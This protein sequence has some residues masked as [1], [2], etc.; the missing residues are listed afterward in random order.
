MNRVDPELGDRLAADYA[1][2]TLRG[3]ARE[4]LDKLL[5]GDPELADKVEEWELRLNLLAESAPT[6]EPPPH[7]WSRVAQQL[8]PAPSSAQ[9]T[10]FGR[11]W[12]DVRFWRGFG[13]LAAAAAAA[14]AFHVAL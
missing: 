7:L 2:G 11:L 6:I 1:L 8:W 3:P 14:L 5:A 4:R 10:W 9:Y 12:N 13:A